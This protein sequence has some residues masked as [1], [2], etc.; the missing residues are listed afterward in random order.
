M[1]RTSRQIF[2]GNVPVG[3][4]AP[5]SIQ[6]MTNVP[7]RDADA[8]LGQISRLAAAGCQIIRVAVDAVE[9]APAMKRICEA[10]PLPVVADVQ[11]SLASGLAALEAGAAAIRINPGLCGNGDELKQVADAV[12]RHH[13]AIRVGANSGSIKPARIAEKIAAG[14][15]GEEALAEALSDA[16]LAQCEALERLGVHSIKAAIKASDV[17]IT[18]AANRRFAARCDHPL[19][20]GVTEAGTPAMGI[21]KSAIGIGA[22]LLDGIGD[23]IRVSLTADPVEEIY[24]A[25]KILSGCGIRRERPEII[26]CPTCGRTGIDLPG[27]VARVEALIE[28][29][30]SSGRGVELDRVAVMGCPV[31]GPGEA[32]GADLGI[33][34]SRNRELVIFEKGKVLGAYPFEQGWKHFRE[35]LLEHAVP[36]QK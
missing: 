20:L 19:H 27:L 26:S 5:V 17:G 1:R 22:L 13:A 34:G 33:A 11:F 2:V 21:V 10:S 14:R 31:N 32:R 16:A 18:V 6:S 4:G 24:A 12:L 3:G 23:T 7:T 28:E 36:S 15:S 30:R 29:L 9:D 35:L 25:R 8:V